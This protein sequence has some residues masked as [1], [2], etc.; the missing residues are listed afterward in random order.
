MTQHGRH[1]S[2]PRP[3]HQDREESVM[4]HEGYSMAKKGG[5]RPI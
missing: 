5:T 4:S 1:D 3:R 2:N